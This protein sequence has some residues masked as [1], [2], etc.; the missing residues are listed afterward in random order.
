[1]QL[2]ILFS[3]ITNCLLPPQTAMILKDFANSTSN[4]S[5]YKLSK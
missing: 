2:A 3:H 5:D 1:M 4:K